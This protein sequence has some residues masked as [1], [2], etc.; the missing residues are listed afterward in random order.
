M[1]ITV[2][3]CSDVWPK[4]IFFPISFISCQE[5]DVHFPP[6]GELEKNPFIFWCSLNLS[7]AAV[8]YSENI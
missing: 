5:S 6:P 4:D 3:K 1:R 8:C 7:K 2:N